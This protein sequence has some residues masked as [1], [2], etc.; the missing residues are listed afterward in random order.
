MHISEGVLGPE[1]LISGAALSVVGVYIGLK[2]LKTDDIPQTGLFAAAFFVASLIHIPVGPVSAHLIFNGIAGFFLGWKAFPAIGIGL[3]L[4]ALLFQFGGITT[5]GINTFNLALPAVLCG[6]IMRK[7]AFAAQS[8]WQFNLAA[9]T[10]GALAILISGLLVGGCLFFNGDAFGA[11]AK[12]VVIA[13]LPVMIV[14]GL[15]TVG[16][17]GFIRRVKPELLRP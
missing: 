2:K 14:E 13:H 11:V 8:L 4:Q 6:V 1:I 3:L 10:C 5:L 7:G 9:F 15:L 16:F 12:I 17:A